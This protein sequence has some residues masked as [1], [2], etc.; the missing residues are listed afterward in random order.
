MPPASGHRNRFTW[1]IFFSLLGMALIT[2]PTAMISVEG[3]VVFGFGAY[4]LF[5]CARN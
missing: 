5:T 1:G 2:V 3:V 4:L